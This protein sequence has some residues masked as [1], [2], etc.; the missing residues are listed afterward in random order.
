MTGDFSEDE[1]VAFV[2]EKASSGE[3]NEDEQSE[4]IDLADS[5][6]ISGNFIEEKRLLL[7]RPDNVRCRGICN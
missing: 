7:L 5:N 3:S 6:V 4:E 2:A 1:E